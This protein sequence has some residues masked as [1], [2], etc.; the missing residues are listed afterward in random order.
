MNKTFFW[1]KKPHVSKIS[2]VRRVALF[3]ISAASSVSGLMHFLAASA[4]N[5]LL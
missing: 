1:G 3:Y 4:I 5:M 2:L